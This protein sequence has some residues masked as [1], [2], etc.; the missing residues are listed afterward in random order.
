MFDEF[1]DP[2]LV[3]QDLKEELE[4]FTSRMKEVVSWWFEIQRVMKSVNKQSDKTISEF[5]ANIK[6][7]KDLLSSY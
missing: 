6:K 4:N 1:L 7:L 3:H 5:E 2:I